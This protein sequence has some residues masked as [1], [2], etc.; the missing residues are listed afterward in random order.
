MK[1]MLKANVVMLSVGEQ[2]YPQDYLAEVISGLEKEVGKMDCNL[3]S[4]HTVMNFADAEKTAEELKD[5]QIDLFI[6]DFV[7]WHIT[8]N[9]MHI[10]KN[11][12]DVPILIWGIGGFTDKTGKLHAPAAGAGVTGF[13]P[14]VKELGFKYKI[15]MEKPDSEHAFATVADYIH[16]VS[17]AKTIKASRIG[18]IGYADM[19]LYSCA[20]DKTGLFKK[21]GIDIENYDGYAIA[22]LM[23]TFDDS[24]V[25]ETMDWIKS[26]TKQQN[27]IPEKALEKVTRLYLAMKGKA[28]GRKLDA[29]S[30]KCVDG[31]TKLGFNPCLAQSLLADKDLS[32][33]CEC[34][35]YGLVT[36][37]I[38]STVTGQ[39]SAFVEH[40]EVF[41]K[42]VLV[43]VCGFIPRD[44]IDGDFNIKAA[45]LGEYNTGISNVSKLKCGEITYGRFYNDNGTFK[46]FLQHGNTK[47]NPK[48]T[49]LGW[50]EPTPDFPAALLE[51]EMS[52]P[53]YIDKVPGQHVIMVFGDHVAK[54]QEVC[55]LL[56]IEVVF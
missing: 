10:L 4:C 30:V 41:D 22:D 27:A 28:D 46:L 12:R 1:N 20:Y 29:I 11:F 33:I 35:A 32:V 39:T 17:C 47:P 38:L 13:V 44:F 25:K 3:L 21:L 37:I 48:W 9:I 40:Y 6:V 8:I 55:N 23:N 7:S 43:G 5:K 31:I 54:V 42:E 45:N 53:E 56:D 18:L 51:V 34:D 2:Q 26:T 52:V 15:I 14:I 36:S 49:E 24:L 50:E 19:G 16:S